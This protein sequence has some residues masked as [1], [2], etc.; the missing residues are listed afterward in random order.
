MRMDNLDQSHFKSGDVVIGSSDPSKSVYSPTGIK[1]DQNGVSIFGREADI[2]AQQKQFED[3]AIK[4]GG[5]LIKTTTSSKS[6]IGKKKNSRKSTEMSKPAR[7]SFTDFEQETEEDYAATPA[8]EVRQETVIFENSF[9]RIKSKVNYVV[10]HPQAIM[11]I[12]ADEDSIVFEPKIGEML[13]LYRD[14]SYRAEQVYYPGVTFNSPD[15]TRKFMIL[16]KVPEENQ[17]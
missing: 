15:S 8:P 13:M 9:G 16:F 10:E 1:L 5:K 7:L 6:H 12:F 4:G 2:R 17:D 14:G 3:V 11:L